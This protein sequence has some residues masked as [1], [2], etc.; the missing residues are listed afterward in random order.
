MLLV[1]CL[2]SVILWEGSKFQALSHLSI[3]SPASPLPIRP[4]TGWIWFLK[5]F[6]TYYIMLVWGVEKVLLAYLGPDRIQFTKRTAY[7]TT[8]IGLC[9]VLLIVNV[10][11]GE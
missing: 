10:P 3:S 11:L 8:F 7:V 4:P 6:G 2:S 9:L 1:L 5:Q